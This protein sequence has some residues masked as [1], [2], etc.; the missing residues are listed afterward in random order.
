[1]MA[2]FRKQ[3]FIAEK[4]GALI[5]GVWGIGGK[6]LL[7]ALGAVLNLPRGQTDTACFQ[8]QDSSFD[9]DQSGCGW[10]VGFGVHSFC[11]LANGLGHYGCQD[12]RNGCGQGFQAY[13]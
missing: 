10:F 2:V 13:G 12:D 11:S 8:A 1:M 7:A 4:F 5:E 9:M 6:L 3:G